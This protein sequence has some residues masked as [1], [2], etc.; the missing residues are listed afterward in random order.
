MPEGPECRRCALSF[1]DYAGGEKLT[2]INILSGRY[3]KKPLPGLKELKEDLPLLVQG[4]GVHGK[5][6]YTIFENKFNLWSTLGMTGSWQKVM[7]NHSRVEMV[8][9]SGKVIYFN[10]MRNFGTLRYC[11]DPKLLASKLESLGPDMLALDVENEIFISQMR[12]NNH[13]NI[14]KILMDQSVI[15]GVGNYI[16]AEA[17]WLARLSPHRK[18]SDISDSSLKILN[19]AIKSV[20]KESFVSGGATIRSYKDFFGESGN[21]GNR[22]MVYNQKNDPDG[23]EVIKEKTPDGRT[24]HWVPEIQR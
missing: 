15:S 2:E 20:M 10:D 24:T 16:K 23:N 22:F 13:H 17:L 1:G 19:K 11:R 18:I 4:V 21:Y 14:T 7:T 6:I 9:E 8:F 5:F 12:K 3:L